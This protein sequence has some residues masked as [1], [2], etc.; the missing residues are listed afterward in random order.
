MR[1]ILDLVGGPFDGAS[2]I[3]ERELRPGVQLTHSEG[4]VFMAYCMS[5]GGRIDQVFHVFPLGP[6][7]RTVVTRTEMYSYAYRIAQ[8]LDAPN[9]MLLVAEFVGHAECRSEQSPR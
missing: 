5:G 2:W 3:C 9:E 1:I 7:T 8:R 6:I 4:T